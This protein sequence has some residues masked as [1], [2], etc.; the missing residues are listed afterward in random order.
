MN[1]NKILIVD[2]DANICEL[3]RLHLVKEGFDTAIAYDGEDAV[4]NGR[5]LSHHT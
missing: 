1:K 5:A 4:K 3:V 2:D